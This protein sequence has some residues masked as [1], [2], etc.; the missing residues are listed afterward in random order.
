MQLKNGRVP[1]EKLNQIL[2]RKAHSV[3]DLFG[4]PRYQPRY[5]LQ[6]H[7]AIFVQYSH[8]I[9]HCLHLNGRQP[10]LLTGHAHGL[11]CSDER[12]CHASCVEHCGR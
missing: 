8:H 10:R 2:S 7:S 12:W 9:M 5:G 6:E 4:S 11:T 1:L 3:A